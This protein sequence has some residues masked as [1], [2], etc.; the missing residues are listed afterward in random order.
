MEIEYDKWLYVSGPTT[1]ER[2]REFFG[3][4]TTCP[5]KKVGFGKSGIKWAVLS[6]AWIHQQQEKKHAKH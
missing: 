1:K 5:A 4:S 2:A 3:V 6:P